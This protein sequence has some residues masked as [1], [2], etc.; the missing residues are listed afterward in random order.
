MYWAGYTACRY[1]PLDDESDCGGKLCED[2]EVG[3][4]DDSHWY[5]CFDDGYIYP[6]GNHI[7][8]ESSEIIEGFDGKD[9]TQKEEKSHILRKLHGMWLFFIN[10]ADEQKTRKE[11]AVF[12]KNFEY[13]NK[14][15]NIS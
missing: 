15:M 12:M 7:F 4:A 1:L 14:I 6:G 3:Y 11:T 9:A 2:A 8:A 5:R 13:K 10:G